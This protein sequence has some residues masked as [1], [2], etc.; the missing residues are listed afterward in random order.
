VVVVEGGG[1][2]DLLLLD[3]PKAAITMAAITIA[4]TAYARVL[5]ELDEELVVPVALIVV[6]IPGVLVVATRVEVLI[7][8]PV[9]A[10]LLEVVFDDRIVVLWVIVVVIGGP[11]SEVVVPRALTG[12]TVHSASYHICGCTRA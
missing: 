7:V 11:P 6:T 4:I 8:I 12:F 1:V 10:E 5:F 3:C 2:L 9:F